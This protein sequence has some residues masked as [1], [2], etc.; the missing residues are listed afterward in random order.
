VISPFCERV[1]EAPTPA[2]LRHCIVGDQRYFL[3]SIAIS[4]HC[5]RYAT[6][7]D[8]EVAEAAYRAAVARWPKARTTLRQGIRVVHD[9][10]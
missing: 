7:D 5:G 9:T 2:R 4:M 6:A 8:F 1:G 10:G 3:D